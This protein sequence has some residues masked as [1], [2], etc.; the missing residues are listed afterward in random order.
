LKIR[1]SLVRFQPMAP[2][3]TGRHGY[4]HHSGKQ[5]RSF[6]L[7]HQQYACAVRRVGNSALFV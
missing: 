6:F 2:I 5:E 1:V 3:L 4:L 7:L